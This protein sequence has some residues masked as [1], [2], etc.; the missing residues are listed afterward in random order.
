MRL[1]VTMFVGF[2]VEALGVTTGVIFGAYHYTD[3]MGPRL[4]E[5]PLVIGINWAIRPFRPRLGRQGAS[6][7]TTTIVACFLPSC[8]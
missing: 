3:R 2:A 7:S 5:V 4:H 8:A 6:R 1:S